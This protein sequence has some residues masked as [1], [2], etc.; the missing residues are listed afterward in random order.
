MRHGNLAMRL[1]GGFE[2]RCDGQIVKVPQSAHRVLSFLALKDRPLPRGYVADSL[3]PDTREDKAYANLRT[4][5]WRLHCLCLD[6]IEVSPGEIALN[7]A[8]SVDV[9]TVHDAACEYRRNGVLP[10]PEALVE[11]HGELLPGCFET[12]LTFERERLRE[13]AVELLEAASRACLVRG[14]THLAMMLCLGAVECDALRESTNLLLVRIC[15]RTGERIRAIR[16][17][18]LYA[19]RLKEELGVSPPPTLTELLDCGANLLSD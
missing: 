19:E 1:F 18:R 11:I 16:H 17:A 14:Q 12:W 9:R 6:L 7:S 2:L 15:D 5:L 13:E 8:V 4:A 10:Q 3:W